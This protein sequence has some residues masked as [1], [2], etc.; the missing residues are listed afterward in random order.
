M[1]RARLGGATQGRAPP[2]LVA[3]PTA[4]ESRAPRHAPRQVP[5]ASRSPEALPRA[6]GLRLRWGRRVGDRED[7]IRQPPLEARVVAE[8][9]EQLHMVSE[10]FDQHALKRLVMLN[11]RV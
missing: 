2:R 4:L 10:E 9:L 8:L 6:A 11:A 7:A 1:V 5:S 3:G